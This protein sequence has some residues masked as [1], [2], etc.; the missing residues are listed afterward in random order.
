MR[1]IHQQA[2]AAAK[3]PVHAADDDDEFRFQHFSTPL[4]PSLLVAM[5]YVS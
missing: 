2:A 4:P 1:E 5:N 3:A